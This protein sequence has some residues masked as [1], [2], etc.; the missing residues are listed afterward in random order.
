VRDPRQ[1]HVLPELR[2][3]A[4]EALLGEPLLLGPGAGPFSGAPM[5]LALVDACCSDEFMEL[6]GRCCCWPAAGLLLV[7]VVV[8]L[9]LMMMMSSRRL[10]LAQR[11]PPAQA[12]RVWDG[13]SEA[14]VPPGR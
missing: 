8:V 11:T 7:G 13:P 1:R 2:A 3:E 6:V 9:L 14:R 5:H 4:F 10:L 12:S